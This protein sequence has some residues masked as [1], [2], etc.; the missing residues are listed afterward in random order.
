MDELL[1]RIGNYQR[2]SS[3]RKLVGLYQDPP[4]REIAGT[5]Q[6]PL[7]TGQALRME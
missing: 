1:L 6:T 4:E 5:G 3:C 2:T 7:A